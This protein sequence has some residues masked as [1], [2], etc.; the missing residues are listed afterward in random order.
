MARLTNGV[1]YEL[2][3]LVFYLLTIVTWIRLVLI[4]SSF[5]RPH[6]PGSLY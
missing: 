5:E 3:L 2:S 1:P 4:H 6:S